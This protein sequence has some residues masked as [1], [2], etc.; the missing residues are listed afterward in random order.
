MCVCVSVSVG[1][2]LGLVSL[3]SPRSCL[4]VLRG[5]IS[6]VASVLSVRFATVLSLCVRHSLVSLRVRLCLVS[7]R[8]P[9][10][11]LCVRH[12]LVSLSRCCV[13]SARVRA[14]ALLVP[15][16][17]AAL[18]CACS[19]GRGVVCVCAR[20][21]CP[22]LLGLRRAAASLPRARPACVRPPR[23]RRA[24]AAALACACS[25]GRAR[26]RPP[27]GAA[28][29]AASAHK[30]GRRPPTV[31]GRRR[32]VSKRETRHDFCLFP[33][34]LSSLSL[35]ARSESHSRDCHEACSCGAAPQA[36]ARP[37]AR[38]VYKRVA[39][40]ALVGPPSGVIR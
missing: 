38:R 13:A 30:Q 25:T 19:P 27:L 37:R 24:A 34:T 3:R 23:S 14:P 26:G 2:C 12:G 4:C 6:A 8:S 39:C 11:C 31:G 15:A 29:E 21:F 28:D 33:L 40:A 7:L 36:A 22:G 16:A 20:V 1:L 18:A 9:R 5:R 17:P 10:S 32:T 35:A